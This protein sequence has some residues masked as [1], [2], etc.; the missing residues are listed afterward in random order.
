MKKIKKRIGMLLA[1]ALVFSLICPKAAASAGTPGAAAAPVEYSLSIDGGEGI[2]LWAYEIEGGVY[3]RLRD[4]AAALS[5]T[6]K[7]FDV[8]WDGSENAV[9]LKMGAA[10]TPAGGELL[11]P[12]PEGAVAHTPTAAY[13]IGVRQITVR[14][15]LV[16]DSHYVK[17]SDLAAG[18]MFA[19]A[20]DDEKHTVE[21]NTGI[22]DTGLYSF[23]LPK[24]WSAEGDGYYLLFSL[25]GDSVG[26]LV[27]RNYDSDCPIS[28]FQDNHRETLSSGNISGFDY[29]AA[30]A[31]IR[32]TQPAAANDDTY[33]DELHIYIMLSDLACAFDI[34]FDSAKVDEQTAMEIAK[35]FVPNEAAL[36]T[37]PESS[38][39]LASLPD[40]NIYIY[41]DKNSLGSPGGPYE[42]LCL[43]INGVCKYFGWENIAKESFL[44][45][46]SLEDLNG[47][48]QNE[49]VI[50]LTTGE[51]TGVNIKDIHVINPES[52][53]ETA[54]ENP[55]D[56]ISQNVF[57][58][59][60]H[61]N[62]AVLITITVNG[63]R[64]LITLDENYAWGWA[65]DKAVFGSIVTYAAD[66]S[67]FKASVPVQVSCTVFIGEIDI[68]Y[69]FDG[70]KY[71]MDAIKYVPYEL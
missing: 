17:L 65:E 4:V 29:P 60:V 8:S 38:I 57:S 9:S 32:A 64:S 54:V 44:P 5:G 69:A 59:I 26:S 27:I 30:K 11:M 34:C 31:V 53:E 15:Y 45:E 6:E 71:V 61:E 7:Q 16:N 13:Y 46:L 18:I 21:I 2:S 67:E 66:G 22:Y 42:G 20:C 43:S 70:N 50:I 35:S 24:G 25:S 48:G 37:I 68:T 58:S 51:G 56:I 14:S 63:Q 3:Y 40:D 28:Q 23:S 52:F 10:Y 41:G 19:S 12:K 49:L 33:V 47:D 55:L 1:A 39:L 62:G 36:K